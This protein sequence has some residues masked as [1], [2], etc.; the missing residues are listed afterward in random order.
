ML[1]KTSPSCSKERSGLRTPQPPE[2]GSELLQPS[3]STE[4]NPVVFF[5]KGLPR[6]VMLLVQPVPERS[7]LHGTGTFPWV[8]P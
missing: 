8:T 6:G 7:S 5:L 3:S 4:G 2:V 1:L